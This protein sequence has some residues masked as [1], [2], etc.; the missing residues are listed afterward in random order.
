MSRKEFSELAGCRPLILD[1]ATGTE[2]NKLGM[3]V[4]ACPERWILGNPCAGRKVAESYRQ[5][6]SDIIYAPSFGANR[7]KLAEFG[8]G[9]DV[10]AINRD[11]AR[12]AKEAVGDGWV[13]GDIA[14]TG[15]FIEPFGALLFDDAVD[16]YR[17]QVIG[18]LEGGVD[19]FAIE[20]MM[21]VQEARSAL[22]AVRELCDLPVI[23]TLTFG[24]DGRSLTGNTPIAALVTMQALGAD[25]FGCNCSTGPDAMLPLLREMKAFAKIPLVAKPNAGMP[26]L[27]DGDTVFG[28]PPAEFAGFAAELVAAG[29]NVIG[30]CC[31]TTPAHIAALAESAANLKPSPPDP[32]PGLV[33]SSPRAIHVSG[34]ACQTTIIGERINPTGKKALKAELLEG[35][36]D[37]VARF[38]AE[39]TAAGANILDI[40]MG[41]GGIDERAMMLKAIGT[42]LR[43]SDLPICVDSTKPEVVE[44][45]LRLYPGRALL[46]SISAERERLEK[47]LPIAAK[48]GAAF[49]LLPLTDDGIPVTVMDRIEV[50]EKI[51]TAAA[52][53][54]YGVDDIAVDGLVMT[55]SADQSAA[56]VTLDLIEWASREL[57][58]NTVCGLSNVS[59][60]LPNRSLV[61][62]SFLAMGIGRGLSMAIANPGSGQLMDILKSS[63]ALTGRDPKLGDYIARFAEKT[64]AAAV[65]ASGAN[66]AQVV[67]DAVIQGDSDG[68]PAAVEAALKAGSS[69]RQLV[70]DRLIPAINEVGELFDRKEYF[71]PQLIA[72]A[73]AMRRGFTVLEPLLRGD[74]GAG[75]SSDGTIV[76]ATVKGDIHDIGKNIAALM[77][78]NYNFKVI[79]LG[80]DVPAADIVAAAAEHRADI[81]GLSALM[82]TTMIQMP[83]VVEAAKAAGLKVKFMVGGAVIDQKYADDIG[84]D[85]YVSDAMAG[86]R[87]A[88][89][90]LDV[91]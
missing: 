19:G 3:P 38:A 54:G 82:T 4:G 11:L 12:L 21:D 29:A 6:G 64:V 51:L 23:V 91:K 79:D 14:P 84:A 32:A 52:G 40:N 8:F 66:P 7:V 10:T 75:A 67:F 18:L 31:G 86:V 59:F 39:Q 13:F 22:I 2:L 57:G 41:M 46:N 63:D 1:G 36:M 25:A 58:A 89:R 48:Y 90:L 47:I 45:A 78:R 35:V 30:G 81:I 55:V 34:A 5:A 49:I 73:D 62:A 77:L 33:V 76:I 70:D 20:T 26:K 16:I 87:A 88:K 56:V 61:N 50:V 83:V 27:V 43:R 15:K 68:I 85:A 28:M 74:G 65:P 44:A 24:E 37:I 72:S 17:E 71:L 9:D 69:P 80:K 42:V 60:G 53:H